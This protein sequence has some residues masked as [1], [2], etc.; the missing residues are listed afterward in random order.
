MYTIWYFGVYIS[1]CL[2]TIMCYWHYIKEYFYFIILRVL[3]IIYISTYV[4][5]LYTHTSQLSFL[6]SD[7]NFCIFSFDKVSASFTRYT[8][9]YLFIF[10][11]TYS[12]FNNIIPCAMYG[13]HYGNNVVHY[14]MLFN[15]KQIVVGFT[16]VLSV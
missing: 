9:I 11:I 2:N 6:R 15:E 8:F 12:N 5:Y 14:I 10:F 3:Y 4:L 13:K 16:Q 7:I 1:T